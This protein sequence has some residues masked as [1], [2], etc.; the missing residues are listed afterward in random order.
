MTMNT[1]KKTHRLFLPGQ[2]IIR[3]VTAI[4]LCMLVYEARGRNGMPIF[5]LIAAVMCI[6]PYTK[7]MKAIADRRIIGTLIGAGFG[8]LTL[9][10]EEQLLGRPVPEGFL[11]YLIAAL[12]AGAVIYFTVWLNRANMAQFAGIVY[13]IIVITQNGSDNVF[14]Y[15]FNRVLDTVIGI[16]VGEL[17]NRV[18]LPRVRNTDTLFASGI[19][20]TMFEEGE[21]LSG[22][23]LIELNRLIEDGCKFTVETIETPASVRE[24]LQNVNFQLPIIAMDGAVLYDMKERAF[25]RT[26]Y[27]GRETADAMCRLLDENRAAF[28]MT[29]LDQQVLIIRHSELHNDAIRDLYARKRVSPY[30]NYAPRLPEEKYLDKTV[31]FC[32]LD[33]TETVN[34]VLAGIE[35]APWADRVRIRPD[36][37]H[38][39]EGYRCVRIFPAEA[40]KESMLARLQEMTGAKKTVTFGSEAGRCDVVIHHANK[41]LMVK[42]L[43]RR[44][45]PVSLKG[46]RNMFAPLLG[47]RR[48]GERK[49]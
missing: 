39:P 46:W 45:E 24:M 14:L 3:T 7:D 49:P 35:G 17:V 42:E 34:R 13:L 9:L 30:R 6:Q 2:R 25:L 47:R 28:F 19:N 11:H 36:D 23:S 40:T 15:A 41:D 12:G 26:V 21:H 5:A 48:Q 32:V 31:Y 44:F 27:M 20:H 10:L 4:L 37:R 29:T 22:Y 18:H 33:E 38:I 16:V 8:V 43:K 1:E